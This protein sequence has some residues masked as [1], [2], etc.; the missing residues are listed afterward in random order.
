MTPTATYT[1]WNSAQTIQGNGSWNVINVGS[2][3]LSSGANITLNGSSSDYFVINVPG[4]FA[5][6]G[7]AQIK[8]TGGLVSSHV[9]INIIGTG[10]TATSKIGNLINA[11][12]LAVNRSVTFHGISGQVICG[13][14]S[15][16]LMS[17]AILNYI[18]YTATSGV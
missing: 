14:Q 17:S 16:T 1:T 13:G 2:I 11:T 12:I 9:L 8:T 4:S 7:N 3:N 6:S 15:L 18:P 10:S 5:M